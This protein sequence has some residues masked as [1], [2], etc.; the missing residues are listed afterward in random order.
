MSPFDGLLLARGGVAYTVLAIQKSRRESA[1]EQVEYTEE[2]GNAR[3]SRWRALAHQLVFIVAGLGL[4][5]LGAHWL[6]EGTVG[7][8]RWLGLSELIIGLTIVAVGTSLPAVTLL[9]LWV[10]HRASFRTR[11]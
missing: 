9:V 4:L 6:V 1:S 8:A 3:D 11:G 7:L 5:V 2:P 10:R